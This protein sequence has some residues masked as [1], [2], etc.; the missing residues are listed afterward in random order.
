MDVD[1]APEGE[2]EKPKKKKKRDSEVVSGR[3]PN[4]HRHSGIDELCA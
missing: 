2:A 4:S 3:P 1:A